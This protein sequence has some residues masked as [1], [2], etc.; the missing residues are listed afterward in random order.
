MKKQS[1]LPTNQPSANKFLRW[2]EL[3]SIG[4]ICTVAGIFIYYY[5]QTY[6]ESAPTKQQQ[7]PPAIE[8]SIVFKD[9]Q[10]KMMKQ[11][12]SK[13]LEIE[14]KIDPI[15]YKHANEYLNIPNSDPKG[16][17]DNAE[18][19]N[20]EQ[21]E[22]IT[23][24]ADNGDYAD[25]YPKKPDKHPVVLPIEEIEKTITKPTTKPITKPKTVIPPL[26][27]ITKTPVP[28]T[29]S[30]T[31]KTI[32]PTPKK[33]IILYEH[34]HFQGKSK[35]VC[36]NTNYIGDA[37][38]DRVSSIKVQANVG[39]VSLYQHRDYQGKKITL[40]GGA[41]VSFVGVNYNDIISSIRFN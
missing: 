12:P 39:T 30:P 37:F 35:T 20:E 34:Y 11:F 18:Q 3:T 6:A 4:V 10:T 40:P 33:C 22:V 41:E 7:E 2:L 19:S 14:L 25:V 8:D 21:S 28:I 31:P 23:K 1:N 24:P 17:I 32:S 26:K 9:I 38:N 15:S 36:S 29:P 13:S 16:P 27:P 5:T